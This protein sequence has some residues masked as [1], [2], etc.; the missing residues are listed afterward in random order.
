MRWKLSNRIA[1]LSAVFPML[2]VIVLSDADEA[3]HAQD[4]LW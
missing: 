4:P 3:G 2:P 1:A